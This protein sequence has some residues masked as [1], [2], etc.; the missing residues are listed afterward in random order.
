MKYVIALIALLIISLSF[1]IFGTK[2]TTTI[3]VPTTEIDESSTTSTTTVTGTSSSVGTPTPKPV[4]KSPQTVSVG[5]N[6]T[7]NI[8][9]LSITPTKVEQDSRCPQDVMCIQAGT[10]KVFTK[11]VS[12]MGTSNPLIELGKPITTEAEII[13][14]IEVRPATLSTK[15]IKPEDYIFVFKVTTR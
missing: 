9:S 2:Q 7:V 12:G 6:K 4:V 14:L 15:Q 10:V 1:F 3:P 5:L 8:F 11:I 13:E